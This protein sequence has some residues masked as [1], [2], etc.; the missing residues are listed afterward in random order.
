MSAFGD[1]VW[2]GQVGFV[3]GWV[4]VIGS[5]I[6]DRV[7]LDMEF[8]DGWV[9]LMGQVIGDGAEMGGFGD[10][11]WQGQVGVGTEMGE[12]SLAEEM[13]IGEDGSSLKF[14]RKKLN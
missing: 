13:L 2:Q 10:G 6:G 4:W 3:D 14:R 5:D 9:C 12:M 7:C 1:G 11:V 8:G